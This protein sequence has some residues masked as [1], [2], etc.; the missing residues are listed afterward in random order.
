MVYSDPECFLCYAKHSTSCTTHCRRLNLCLTCVAAQFDGNENICSGMLRDYISRR[1][2]YISVGDD[3]KLKLKCDACGDICTAYFAGLS[4]C[5]TCRG[6]DYLN[7]PHSDSGSSILDDPLR[8]IMFDRVQ[9]NTTPDDAGG[10]DKEGEEGGGGKGGG[11]DFAVEEIKEDELN[12]KTV[13][14]KCYQVKRGFVAESLLYYFDDAFEYRF[15][16]EFVDCKEC[17]KKNW[18]VEVDYDSVQ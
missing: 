5:S 14:Q 2:N 12:C 17:G 10:G 15:D 6:A 13:C 18:G 8:D 1:S 4:T 9:S 3:E 16:F 11:D 7:C